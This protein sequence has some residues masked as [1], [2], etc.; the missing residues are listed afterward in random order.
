MIWGMWQ[1]K[2]IFLKKTKKYQIICFKK[3]KI[4]NMYNNDL[5]FSI[6][7]KKTM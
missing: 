4:E 3:L 5:Y 2:K 7:S 6:L 1:S